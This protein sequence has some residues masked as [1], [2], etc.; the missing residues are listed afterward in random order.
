MK[1][2][3]VGF[4][5]NKK[6]TIDGNEGTR[7]QYDDHE[8]DDQYLENVGCMN[9]LFGGTMATPKNRKAGSNTTTAEVDFNIN[10]PDHY[11]NF[12]KNDDSPNLMGTMKDEKGRN[13]KEESHDDR[14][15]NHVSDNP[16]HTNPQSERQEIVTSTKSNNPMAAFQCHG[17][18]RN[19][20][21]DNTKTTVLDPSMFHCHGVRG[22]PKKFDYSCTPRV[23]QITYNSMQRQGKGNTGHYNR[24]LPDLDEMSFHDSFDEKSYVLDTNMFG[25]PPTLPQKVG[26]VQPKKNKKI[27]AKTGKP[28]SS[29]SLGE[30]SVDGISSRPQS[31]LKKA[32]QTKKKDRRLRQQVDKTRHIGN[33][34]SVP[35]DRTKMQK[36][37]GNDTQ[38]A[39]KSS[40]EQKQ[41]Q[42]SVAEICR[43]RMAELMLDGYPSF[44]T[45]KQ[46]PPNSIKNND[47][48]VGENREKASNNFTGNSGSKAES[49]LPE[50][51]SSSSSSDESFSSAIDGENVQHRANT[52]TTL[53][54]NTK[55]N[56]EVKM[57]R[58]CVVDDKLD[59]P[60]QP[61]ETSR[62]VLAT[63][64][65]PFDEC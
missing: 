18:G 16:I 28:Q 4:N 36:I 7:R 12:M 1:H 23:G 22:P 32:S 17:G 21:D 47:K 54:S 6:E 64:D 2:N 30:S 49:E 60:I 40:E 9:T 59:Y 37:S 11:K 63:N 33:T 8:Q 29:S 57:G 51:L 24:D 65:T 50:I 19:V 13:E 42:E 48:V 15:K 25:P 10:L 53:I 38:L 62:G 31:Q 55:S 45:P 46:S 5:N 26:R 14:S 34:I 39:T 35:I 41:L 43:Q 52:P 58:K 20:L 44:D 27:K 61:I 56:K 3:N